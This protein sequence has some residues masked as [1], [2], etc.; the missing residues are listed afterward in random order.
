MSGLANTGIQR[1]VN[2]ELSSP[3]ARDVSSFA[4]AQAQEVSHG[5][6][7]TETAPSILT[8][9]FVAYQTGTLI[10][11]KYTAWDHPSGAAGAGYDEQGLTI[12][13]NDGKPLLAS[14]FLSSAGR[15]PS[16]TATLANDLQTQPGISACDSARG[17]VSDVLQAL[18]QGGPSEN[19]FILN[20]TPAG[21]EFS[22]QQAVFGDMACQPVA[23]L[24]LAQLGGLA[25]PTLV[26]LVGTSPHTRS[27]T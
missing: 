2:E 3:V 8:V 6:D 11:V 22:F 9:V 1:E 17:G 21:L 27:R 10:S 18:L 14:D 26:H 20:S 12:D 23:T 7:F 13:L 5:S 19:T 16:G 24:S 4:V 15:S 25:N